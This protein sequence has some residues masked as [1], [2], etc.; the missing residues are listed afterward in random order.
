MKPSDAKE[1]TRERKATQRA[2]PQLPT[3]IQIEEYPGVVNVTPLP[4]QSRPVT[5]L[6]PVI[7]PTALAKELPQRTKGRS[8]EESGY[9]AGQVSVSTGPQGQQLWRLNGYYDLPNRILCFKA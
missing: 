9:P 8:P 1:R 5:P 6:A 3:T 7:P 4:K 2:K